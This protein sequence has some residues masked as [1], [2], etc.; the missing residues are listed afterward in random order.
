M[1]RVRSS[2]ILLLLLS[3]TVL[4]AETAQV[5]LHNAL[6]RTQASAVVLDAVT[7]KILTR[8]GIPR[9]G[10]PGSTMKPFVLDYAL[11][12]GLVQPQT[13]AYCRRDLHIGGRSVPC[14][15]PADEPFF[16]AENALAESCNTWFAA[17]AQRMPAGD[18][19]QAVAATALPHENLR[20]ANVDQRQL[21]VLGL[22]GSTASPLELARAYRSLFQRLPQGGVVERGLQASVERGMANPA[23]TRGI[24]IL[25]KTGTARNP[26]ES[27]THG[28]FAGVVPG[29][30]IVVIYIPKGDGGTAAKLAH[31]FFEEMAH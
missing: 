19:E 5:A 22:W 23:A 14:T 7:G 27:W 8:E 3:A 13:Q 15:H 12:H 29:R 9:R 21:A 1:M 26:G 30:W 24:T 25:G 28:W 18:V 16:D 2:A 11:Q 17:L 4:Q 10:T 20:G 6:A 31:Q